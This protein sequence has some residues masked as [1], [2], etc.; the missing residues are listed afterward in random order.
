MTITNT[1]NVGSTGGNASDVISP[2][3][4]SVV[5]D[6]LIAA[7]ATFD[8]DIAFTDTMVNDNKG[9]TWHLAEG[10][11]KGD[12]LPGSGIWYTVVTTGGAATTV[13]F[14]SG[15]GHGTYHDI[16]ILGFHSTTGWATP[17]DTTTHANASDISD[18]MQVTAAAA[19]SGSQVAVAVCCT[20]TGGTNAYAPP[21]DY[22]LGYFQNDGSSYNAFASA[23]RIGE[24]G[25]PSPGFTK[26]GSSQTQASQTFVTFK[27]D[28][29][30][31]DGDITGTSTTVLVYAGIG[32]IGGINPDP[33]KIAD[34]GARNNTATGNMTIALT[35]PTEIA[36]G[37]YLV[38]R[39]AVDNSGT[40]GA[41]PGL[42]LTDTRNGTWVHGTGGLQDPGAASAGIAVYLCYVKVTTPY[43]AGDVTTFTWGG[44]SPRSAV[45]IEEWANIDQITPLAVAENQANNVS[46][47]AQPAISRTPT[48]VGQL[49]YVCA[50]IEGFSSSWG[51]QD[52]DS[53]DGTWSDLTKA[54]ANTGTNT[55]SVSVYGGYKVVTST[56]AQTWNNTLGATSDWAACA[57]VFA[58]A[59]TPVAI[60]G[61]SATVAIVADSGVV[62]GNASVSGTSV[63][64]A[65]YA[66][67]GTIGIDTSIIGTS[68]TVSVIAGT[69]GVV[70]NASVSGTSA[71]VTVIA[72]I[73]S[74]GGGALTPFAHVQTPAGGSSNGS[75]TSINVTLPNVAV[76]NLLVV[77]WRYSGGGRTVTVSDD[78]GENWNSSEISEPDPA[79]GNSTV[80]IAW[81]ADAVGGTTIVTFGV[82]GGAVNLRMIASEYSTPGGTITVD[83][84]AGAHGNSTTPSTAPVTPT[85]DGQLFI[86]GCHT[87]D[88]TEYTQGTDFTIATTVPIT[89]YAQRLAAEYYVQPISAA[90][91]GDFII[92]APARNFSSALATFKSSDTGPPNITGTPATV[93]VVAGTGVIGGGA[94]TFT[95]NFT[96]TDGADLGNGWADDSAFGSSDPMIITRLNRGSVDTTVPQIAWKLHGLSLE[97]HDWQI[98]FD[99]FAPLVIGNGGVAFGLLSNTT[100]QGWSIFIGNAV[101]IQKYNVGGSHTNL[102]NVDRPGD[103]GSLQN[104]ITF[105]HRGS[106]GFM[107]V[108][109]DGVSFATTTD[110]TQSAG[111]MAFLN[112]QD[113]NYATTEC[114]IDN[115]VVSDAITGPPAGTNITG[116]SATVVSVAGT[117]TITATTAITGISTIVTVIAG[118]GSIGP[119]SVL[120]PA[121]ISGRK[122]LDQNGDVFLMRTFSSWGMAVQLTDA[123]ITI[124]LTK[125]AALGFNAVTIWMSGRTATGWNE[126]TTVSHGNLFTGTPWQSSLGP[127]WA[128]M[129]WI[130]SEAARLGIIVNMSLGIGFGGN[131]AGDEI[132]TA[133]TTQM[134]DVGVALATR[135]LA[136]PN[137]VWHTMLDWSP[138]PTNDYGLRVEAFF[139]GINSVEDSA[140]PVRW[141]EP[142]NGATTYSQGWLLYGESKFSSNTV[143]QYHDDSTVR[144]DA[145]W[146]ESGAT[147]VPVMDCEPPYVGAPHYG[148][149]QR[150]QLRE[151]TWSVFLR[152]GWGINFGHEDYWSFGGA[153]LYG[154]EWT[155]NQVLDNSVEVVQQSYI[156]PVLDTYARNSSWVPTDSF[157]T[158]GIG[159][160]D[161]K[162]ASGTSG[163]AAIVYFP[164]SRTVTVDTT[165]LNGSGNVR[166]RWYDPYTGGYTTIAASET[167]QSGRSISYPSAHGDGTND[168]V[169]VVDLVSGQS[170]ITGTSGI[171]TVIAGTGVIT[172]NASVTGTSATVTVIAGT[173]QIG[174]AGNITGISATVIVIA[175]TGAITGNSNIIGTSATVNIVAGTGTISVN[176]TGTGTVVSVIAGTGT[177]TGNTNV[178]GTSAIVAV[179]AGVGTIITGSTIVGTSGTVYVVAGTGAVSG[180]TNV[181]GTSLTVT[182]IAATGVV[183]GQT[184]II[185]TS[186]TVIV[187]VGTGVITGRASV[188]GTSTVVTVIA[189]TG[190]IGGQV[191][192]IGTSV[193]VTVISGT[194]IISGQ[195]NI[196]G[197]TAVVVVRAGIGQ[198]ANRFAPP[199]Q[200]A[201]LII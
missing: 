118:I 132:F 14:Q 25:T 192:V 44:S 84:T 2:S 66:D 99:C 59:I 36:V 153:K 54:E 29:G 106:D 121:S 188:I 10:Q 145:V 112:L 83:K 113:V 199:T 138:T 181:T 86:Y 109:L 13:T 193:V 155:W 139:Q 38:A 57:V 190:V 165:I 196:S 144:F 183:G 107:E 141:M 20:N 41:R 130:V 167:Q 101:H 102:T 48:A 19:I 33:V 22:L 186:A 154:G 143:Y 158:T 47:T 30:G 184:N 77:V 170:D 49:M 195:T 91:V 115:L 75:A 103:T 164:D 73:G 18:P 68:A 179:T 12:G 87:D 11:P 61:T 42:T 15:A 3:F 116:T 110:N 58:K 133:S 114:W 198:I 21:T 135:Y 37:N 9:N 92:L 26:A 74:V 98:D 46:S 169:L 5:G 160:G 162:G 172:G 71:T 157:V 125:L 111:N 171:V 175:G 89:A 90:H 150:Q 94:Q 8:V 50:G 120:Y 194:G 173:G 191:N 131:V 31:A 126:Y 185:G 64:V 163:T 146:N 177:I 119:S 28:A 127:G 85:T 82:S 182:V 134:H 39:V 24:T 161:T 97:S 166:L 80:G 63:I 159:S 55:T 174:T 117:G 201:I 151:R 108:F 152:G 70:G 124:E 78:K 147:T 52:S 17:F 176:I 100:F 95:E 7:V 51:A 4:T 81:F 6:L 23:Y 1:I 43:Q 137:I 189:G 93:L 62:T 197:V 180:Q 16:A 168:W 156:F 149:N 105:T 200:G 136:S 128:A 40:S 27:E 34:R 67:T 129:D 123:Q 88:N 56:A 122:V 96:G 53:T 65:S 148:G 45:V 187:N 178:T 69:G 35:N 32:Q 79:D 76:G 142:D 72:G 140:R 104:H 60:T